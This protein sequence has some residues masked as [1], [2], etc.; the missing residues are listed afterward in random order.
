MGMAPPHV[1]S[2]CFVVPCMRDEGK[3]KLQRPVFKGW[4]HCCQTRPADIDSCGPSISEALMQP[5]F[6]LASP[7]SCKEGWC[8]LFGGVGFWLNAKPDV[9]YSCS[10][11]YQTQLQAPHILQLPSLL[12]SNS[13]L[14]AASFQAHVVITVSHDMHRWRISD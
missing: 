11:F 8:N 10:S 4:H 6:G 3:W 13:L 1:V 2:L 7:T 5:C 9:L 12:H 14:N